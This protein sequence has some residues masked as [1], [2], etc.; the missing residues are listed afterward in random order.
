MRP[1]TPAAAHYSQAE[2]P[3]ESTPWRDARYCVVD[4]ETTGLDPL[5]DEI[6]SFA[7]IPVDEGR[8]RLGGLVTGLVRPRRMPGPDTMRIHGLRPADL[9]AA[10]ALGDALD[11]MLAALSGRT[12]VAHVARV[13]ERFL[14]RALRG[15][16]VRLRGGT[17]DTARLAEAVLG[18]GRGPDPLALSAVATGMGLPVH[19]PHHA[20]GDALT[21]AQVFIALAARLERERGPQTV[22]SLTRPGG[23]LLRRRRR[24]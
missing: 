18:P 17:I 23:R 14:N 4:L 21:T 10:P 3:A 12:L 5:N 24:R 16:G 11:Q 1:G 15:H 6:I 9:E 7:A 19:R 8:V 13:E 22:H 20:D 2:I